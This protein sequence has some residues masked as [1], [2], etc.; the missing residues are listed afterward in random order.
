MLSTDLPTVFTILAGMCALICLICVGLVAKSVQY[1]RAA[2]RYVQRE[3][4]E[5]V[6]RK[7]LAD[8]STGITEL[9]DAYHALLDSHKKLRSRVGMRELREKRKSNVSSEPDQP[10]LPVALREGE[11]DASKDPEGWKH[12]ARANL[13]A[14][15]L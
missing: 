1:S 2:W 12:W 8:L 10:S 6:T 11:P 9:D 7:Q 15:K 3:N 4:V 13:R 14:G 5:S